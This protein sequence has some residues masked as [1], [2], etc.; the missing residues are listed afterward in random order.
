MLSVSSITLTMLIIVNKINHF[1]MYQSNSIAFGLTIPKLYN[2]W[3]TFV[4]KTENTTTHWGIQFIYSLV[5]FCLE[6]LI[7][8]FSPVIHHD[9]VNPLPDL[10]DP[11]EAGVVPALL[12]PLARAVAGHPYQHVLG[13]LLVGQR[14]ATVSLQTKVKVCFAVT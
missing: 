5:A 8:E 6:A 10:G 11:A 12:A 9:L 14:A 7:T 4:Y 1:S 13:T 2:T 3:I